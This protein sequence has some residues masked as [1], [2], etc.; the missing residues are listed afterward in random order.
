M[1]TSIHFF[2]LRFFLP[3]LYRTLFFYPLSAFF[4]VFCNIIG[5]ID[6]DDFELMGQITQ[7][8]SPFKQDPH[9]GKLLNLLQSLEQLCE[10][11]FQASSGAPEASSSSQRYIP[12]APLRLSDNPP[13]PVT[14]GAFD[15]AMP[16]GDNM[17]HTIDTGYELSADWMMWQ[18]FNSQ[19]EPGWLNKDFDFINF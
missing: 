15:P 1:P 11:L 2:V 7:R 8:L 3:S 9:L 13:D 19:V 5:T 18:L 12:A 10:P 14:T 17:E 6:H 4:V 16:F